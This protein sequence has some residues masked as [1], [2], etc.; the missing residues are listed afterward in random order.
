MNPKI[1]DTLLCITAVLSVA[2]V[3]ALYTAGA[4]RQ[5]ALECRGVE[6][7]VRDSSANRFV[8]GNDVKRI[9]SAAYGSFDGVFADSLDLVAMETLIEGKSVIRDC[10]AYVTRDG[11]LNLDITQRTPAVRFQD[12][13]NGWYADAD[14]YIF[15]L[16]RSHT[17]MVPVVDGDFP[18][19]V[20]RGFKGPVENP[21]Q[22]EWLMRVVGMVEYMNSNG[23]GNRISQIHVSR[24]GEVRLIPTEGNERFV[25]GQPVDIRGK[26]A[27]IE[28]YYRMIRPLAKKYR[29]IDLRFDGQIVCRQEYAEQI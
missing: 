6:V 22:R 3:C 18:V 7:T 21:Q 20:P 4:R 5:A 1:T 29:E 27:K 17:S 13:A 28:K 25:F 9:L 11:K 24:N 10:E 15:P 2:A 16:Q 26:F 14:G 12:A 23:W 8:S 19:T